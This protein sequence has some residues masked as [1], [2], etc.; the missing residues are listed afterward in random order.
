MRALLAGLA[1]VVWLYAA[2]ALLF[3]GAGF[4]AG[5]LPS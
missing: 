5:A 2:L 4:L 1:G 3:L